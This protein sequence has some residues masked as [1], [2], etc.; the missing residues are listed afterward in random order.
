MTSSKTSAVQTV[1]IS[2]AHLGLPGD[3][4]RQVSRPQLP[5]TQNPP[6]YAY[7]CLKSRAKRQSH[8]LRSREFQKPGSSPLALSRVTATDS[9]GAIDATPISES[10]ISPDG[11]LD[12]EK[13]MH[14]E[15]VSDTTLIPESATATDGTGNSK[16]LL[17]DFE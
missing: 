9:E 15:D 1:P 2:H 13:S 16:S 4:K 14:G 8:P 10:I 11:A 6:S 17:E 7:L 5:T 3:A 12:A